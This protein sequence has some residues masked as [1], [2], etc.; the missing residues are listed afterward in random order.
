[1]LQ[2]ASVPHCWILTASSS[3]QVFLSLADCNVDYTSPTDFDTAC[4]HVLRFG[5]LRLSSN[6]IS[7]SVSL[8]AFS[9]SMGDISWYICNSRCPHHYENS[10][11]PGATEI[12]APESIFNSPRTENTGALSSEVAFR[13]MG[14]KTIL[15]LESMDA[16]IARRGLPTANSEGGNKVH[17]NEPMVTVSLT[18]GEVSMYACKDSFDCFASSIG[19][20]QAKMTA[21]NNAGLEELRSK[22]VAVV[23]NDETCKKERFFD[24]Q[25]KV[26]HRI[27]PPEVYLLDGYEWTTIDHDSH[28]TTEI[29]P[30]EEQVARWYCS[31][32]S[33]MS[34]PETDNGLEGSELSSSMISSTSDTAAPKANPSLRI[35]DQ[36]FPLHVVSDP[37]SVG[38]MDAMKLVGGKSVHVQTRVLLHEMK[39]KVRLFDGYDWPESR[40]Q[41]K[42]KPNGLFVI[43]EPSEPD[44]KNS[45]FDDTA[46]AHSASEKKKE[47]L[48]ELLA[49]PANNGT[50]FND[51]PLPE[52][53]V[54]SLLTQAELRRLSRRTNTYLQISASGLRLRMDAYSEAEDHRLK[55]CL[56][57]A[58]T[59]FFVA[60]TISNSNGPV[61]MIGEWFNEAEHPRDSK[62]GLL[63][64]KVN[65]YRDCTF[66]ATIL[67]VLITIGLH[68]MFLCRW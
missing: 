31:T 40:A 12:L 44:E 67:S 52:E 39:V 18:S 51:I 36:H 24:A 21:I 49:E 47:L 61:K 34:K 50:T 1:M 33:Q 38:D 65:C 29:P 32:D 41:L 6:I 59:D 35:I 17:L 2:F 53:R 4:R 56:D 26:S 64:L 9:F 43:D 13:E 25:S 15:T 8:Q 28:H 68:S 10:L 7:P 5:D 48:G 62:D 11:L 45:K 27:S 55:S 58:M 22:S 54:K 20:L 60:E 63:M 23:D 57:L 46:T 66:I 19:E 30:G 42:R 16:I 14:F 37:L 3:L